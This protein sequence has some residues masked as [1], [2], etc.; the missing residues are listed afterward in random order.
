MLQAPFPKLVLAS[1][2]ASRQALLAAAGL[3]FEMRPARIDEGEIKQSAK[4]EGMLAAD[5]AI[6]LA[7]MKAARVARGV[8]DAVVIGADQLL[9]CE[10]H[11]FDKPRDRM[12]AASQLRSLMGRSHELVTAVV[13]Y[14]G[15]ERIWH[16]MARP[17]LMMRPLSDAFLSAYLDAEG[18]RVG[19][20]VGGYRLEGLGVH[21]FERVEGEHSAI[22][23]LP[24]VPL[25]GFLRQHGCVLA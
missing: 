15:G 22:L 13:C 7:D 5:C 2:S 23:G 21:L 10:G 18:E 20:T 6:L 24:M 1:E 11:W 25:L 9:V 4:A 3:V 19:E 8:P 16:H 17:R 14:R 12:E